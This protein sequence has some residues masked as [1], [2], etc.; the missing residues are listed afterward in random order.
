M[1]AAVPYSVPR[2]S[3]AL[4]AV[5]LA[6]AVHAALLAFLW[7]GVRWQNE[8]PVAIEAEVWDVTPSEAAPPPPPV[9]E[10]VVVKETPRPVEPPAAK[11]DIVLEQEKKRKEQAQRQHD[12]EM[13]QKAEAEA[14]KKQELKEKA[15]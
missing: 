1:S 12:E 7:F 11:P 4:P 14:K 5:L 6:L 3:G 13:Q 10:P 8:T 2:E 15:L 9:P